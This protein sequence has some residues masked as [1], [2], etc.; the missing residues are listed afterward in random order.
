M[1]NS[2][3]IHVPI[4][5]ACSLAIVPRITLAQARP[6]TELANAEKQ[7]SAVEKTGTVSQLRGF[8]QSFPSTAH[9]R[10][11]EMKLARLLQTSA[12]AVSDIKALPGSSS[13]P[14]SCVLT[15]YVL[16]GTVVLESRLGRPTD[17]EEVTIS[18]AGTGVRVGTAVLSHSGDVILFDLGV[19]AVAEQ[20]G[21]MLNTAPGWIE[22]KLGS[23]SSGSP[24]GYW[25]DR[26]DRATFFGWLENRARQFREAWWLFLDGNIHRFRGAVDITG[27]AFQGESE[28]LLTFV[29][30][31]RGYIYLHGKGSVTTA[32]G[33]QLTFPTRQLG[34]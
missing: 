2:Y 7:W 24:T 28:D 10:D 9:T 22:E 29:I 12:V 18:S 25:T 8:L 4:A 34:K 26:P 32:G 31:Q 3:G 17:G 1:M 30:T 21:D 13:P 14:I 5:L 6:E 33:K 16:K 11:A 15:P 27:N 23:F 20:K 19:R